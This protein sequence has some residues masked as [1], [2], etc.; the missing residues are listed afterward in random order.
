MNTIK[1][2]QFLI[3]LPMVTSKMYPLYNIAVQQ[4]KNKEYERF[5]MTATKI[6]KMPIKVEST[7]NSQMKEEILQYLD[8]MDL[9]RNNK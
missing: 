8:N 4:Y 3:I 9:S 7:A 5:K 6:M 1:L 2:R